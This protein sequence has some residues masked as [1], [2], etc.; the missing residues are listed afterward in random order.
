MKHIRLLPLSLASLFTLVGAAQAPNLASE[1][2]A[3]WAHVQFLAD[4]KLEGRNVNTPGYEKAVEYVE[5]QFRAIGL[6]PAGTQG[7]RQPVGFDSRRLV[8]EQSSLALVRDGKEQPLTIGADATLNARAELNGSTEASMVFVGYG[9]SIP[10]AGWDDLAGQD[11]RGKIAVYVN[12]FAP[13]QV[14]DNVKSHANTADERWAA[15]KRAGGIGVA[16][17]APPPAQ[18]ARAGGGGGGRGGGGGGGGRGL[19]AVPAPVIMLSDREAQGMAGQVIAM[20]VTRAGAAKLF[21]GSAHTLDEIDQLAREN[22]PLPRFALPGKLKARAAISRETFDASNVAGLFEGS[23]PALKSEYVIMTAHLDHVGIGNEVNGDRIYN[24]AMDDASG[25]AAMIEIARM[26]KT[27][28]AK[29]K[30]SIVFVAVTAEEKGL[31]GSRYFAARPTVPFDKIVADINLD[32][33]LPLYPLKVIEVQGL[34]ESSLGE[35]V[36]AVAKAQGVD[37]QTDREPEQNRFIRSDQYSFIR[38]G[39]PA[40]AFKFG[41]EFGSPE[42]TIRLNWVRDVYHKPSDDSKQPV[43]LE[44]AAKFNRVIMAL[45]QRV[46]DDTARP[47]WNADSFF[48]RFSTQ[49]GSPNSNTERGGTDVRQVPG[50]KIGDITTRGNIIQLEWDAAT[51]SQLQEITVRLARFSFPFSGKAWTR[52]RC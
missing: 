41:Y 6:K 12:A 45:L 26:L 27:S 42:Q 14:S 37:V 38:R 40:L 2:K 21:A 39:V 33:F 32:M 28:G 30:R 3:W 7:F 18:P 17:I 16:I 44:A 34:A 20:N 31:L 48:K 13:V 8:P 25:V 43:D 1:G 52:C 19:V 51:G 4:D 50:R 23:D 5:G 46:A 49:R 36:R 10:D 11:L 35:T 47:T 15:V 24:G 9:L 22:Q 29:T